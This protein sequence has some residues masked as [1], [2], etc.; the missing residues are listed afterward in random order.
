M[1]SI[2]S[3]FKQKL[4]LKDV[5][6]IVSKESNK[7]FCEIMKWY[8][9]GD[10]DAILTLNPDYTELPDLPENVKHLNLTNTNIDMLS[11]LP[12]NLESLVAMNSKL[13]EI[14]SLP[15]SLTLLN[16][17][18]TFVKFL[19]E[20]PQKLEILVVTNN[21]MEYMPKMIHTNLRI[22]LCGYNYMEIMP[23]LPDTLETLDCTGCAYLSTFVRFPLNV[24]T[25][26]RDFTMFAIKEDKT[27]K[28]LNNIMA[29]FEL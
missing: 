25:F 17:G 10:E 18:N 5:F 4:I 15:P 9:E 16:I 2:F 3:S 27:M 28:E 6:T 19:P 23:E 14:K 11:N 20:L 8:E 21:G 22:L 13:S 12:P 29:H 24:H 1:K 26:E 7:M